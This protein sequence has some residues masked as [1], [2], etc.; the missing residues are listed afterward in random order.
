MDRAR[1]LPPLGSA[2]LD[3]AHLGDIHGVAGTIGWR[4]RLAGRTPGRRLRVLAVVMG[5]GLLAMMAANDAGG[6]ATYAQSG[7]SQGTRLLWVLVLLLP[8]LIVNQEMAARLGAVSGVGHARLIFERFG[9]LWGAFALGDLLVLNLL[10]LVTEFIGVRLAA[11]YLGIP[12]A[13]AVP[14]AGLVLLATTLSGSFRRWECAM[15]VLVGVNLVLVPLALV[16]HPPGPRALHDALVPGVSGRLGSSAILLVVALAGTT[17]APWQLFLQQSNVVDK[18]ITPRWLAYERADTAIGAVL[19]VLAAAVI[20]IATATAVHGTVEHEGVLAWTGAPGL[21][22]SAGW[23][24]GGLFAV[25]LLDGAVL[26]AAAVSLATAYAVGDV[27]GIRHSLHRPL[28]K[29]PVFYAVFVLVIAVSAAIALVPGLPLGLVTL[30]VQALAGVLLPSASVFLLLLCNDTAVLGPWVNP[31]WLNVVAS[32]TIAALLL[33]SALLLTRTLHP[34]LPMTGLLPVLSGLTVVTLALVGLL[35]RWG[36][37]RRRV[38][39]PQARPA[40]RLSIASRLT[41]LTQLPSRPASV[42]ARARP[43]WRMPPLEEL[44]RPVWSRGRVAALVVLR[45][46]L[47][48]SAVLLGVR[49]VATLLGHPG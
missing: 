37:R 12:A 44:K 48:V 19:M 42:R 13:A 22:A 15:Y 16:G 34:A 36:G 18:R 14:A 21:A 39:Q 43:S 49:I 32:T 3:E 23:A 46:Y 1:P 47:A 31:R 5:P 28:S 17:I 2:V 24:A 26:G 35:T 27:T 9:R 45:A 41:V 8:V 10:T 40:P 25:I 33:L 11:A 29:A 38:R 7:Q 20:M 6:V 30:A 4:L